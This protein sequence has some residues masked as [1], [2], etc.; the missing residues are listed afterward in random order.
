[1][2]LTYTKSGPIL[3]E[4]LQY[5]AG[6]QQYC[7]DILLMLLSDAGI[8]DFRLIEYGPTELF[9]A[10]ILGTDR[11]KLDDLKHA[12]IL[13]IPNVPWLYNSKYLPIHCWSAGDIPVNPQESWDVI[14]SLEI[15][16]RNMGKS[17]D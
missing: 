11:L 7:T 8:L 13:H 16:G 2:Q 10:L 14:L 12:M 3:K 4:N 5:V 9:K 6:L 17:R 1:M 15:L